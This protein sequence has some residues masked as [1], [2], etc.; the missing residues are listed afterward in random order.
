F[1]DVA[2]FDPFVKRARLEHA[3]PDTLEFVPPWFP[4]RL[5]ALADRGDA[6][7]AFSGLVAPDVF[8]GVDPALLGRDQLPRLKESARVVGERL[9]NWTAVPCP[10]PAWAA[11]VYPELGEDAAY[12]RLWEQLW[13]VL[14]LDEDDPT[15][16]WD[17]RMAVLKGSAE[18]LTQR[19]F[20]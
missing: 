4:A 17:E 14:R 19:R 3:D 15:A 6:R 18:A 9:T 20:D 10:H 1:V 7:M 16:A 12:E 5:L 2:Y 8:A 11:L 13:H